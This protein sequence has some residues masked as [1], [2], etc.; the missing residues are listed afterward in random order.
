MVCRLGGRILRAHA[1][2]SS[3]QYAIA[4]RSR[5]R[6]QCYTFSFE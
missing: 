6:E 3:T 2:E 5:A 4:T 1:D